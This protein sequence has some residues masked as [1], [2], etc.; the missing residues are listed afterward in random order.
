MEQIPVRRDAGCMASARRRHARPRGFARGRDRSGHPPAAPPL[1]RPGLHDA[2]VVL[3]RTGRSIAAVLDGGRCRVVSRRRHVACGRYGGVEVQVFRAPARGYNPGHVRNLAAPI[4]VDGLAVAS[5]ADLL[6]SKLDVIMY[7]PKLRDYVDLAAIDRAGPYR[8]EDG[9]LFHTRRYGSVPEALGPVADSGAV[10]GPRPPPDRPHIRRTGGPD[11]RISAQPR[12]GVAAPSAVIA[13]RIPSA[14]G[15][16][17]D[18]PLTCRAGRFAIRRVAATA[19]RR[20]RHLAASGQVRVRR[21]YRL[22]DP[23]GARSPDREAR[24]APQ[25]HPARLRCGPH[26]PGGWRRQVM[27][28]SAGDAAQ[29]GPAASA[30]ESDRKL[31]PARSSVCRGRA[32]RRRRRWR[33]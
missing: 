18:R 21:L 32:A 24:T 6:A 30:H 17:L 9:L 26:G 20:R 15:G 14:P 22:S 12:A 28:S 13:R 27:R 33:G 19:I 7:R 16:A 1:V 23:G 10:G 8:I 2:G 4:R 25:C 11:A 3:R 29:R 5:L 31:A